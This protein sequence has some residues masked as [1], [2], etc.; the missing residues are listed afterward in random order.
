MQKI[1]K[2]RKLIHRIAIIRIEVPVH[3]LRLQTMLLI[4]KE[5]LN[6]IYFSEQKSSGEQHRVLEVDIVICHTVHKHELFGVQVIQA[7][8]TVCSKNKF[9]CVKTFI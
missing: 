2:P 6:K 8:L 1:S 5:M 7:I 9:F 3:T 4:R